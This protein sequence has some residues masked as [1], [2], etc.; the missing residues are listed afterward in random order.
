MHEKFGKKIFSQSK[1]VWLGDLG[2]DK[3]KNKIMY[4][5][6]I[7]CTTFNRQNVF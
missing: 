6:F 7:Y 1:P 2:R 5:G 3:N 4:W